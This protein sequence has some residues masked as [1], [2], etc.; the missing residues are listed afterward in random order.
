[1]VDPF[2]RDRFAVHQN[3]KKPFVSSGG[4]LTTSQNKVSNPQSAQIRESAND[5]WRAMSF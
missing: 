4:K 1:M 3:V 2:L 5:Y